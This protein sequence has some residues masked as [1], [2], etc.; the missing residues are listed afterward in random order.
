MLENFEQKC[1]P[2]DA[3]NL[4]MIVLQEFKFE[5]SWKKIQKE[6]EEAQKNFK[7]KIKNN[8]FKRAFGMGLSKAEIAQRESEMQTY[9]EDL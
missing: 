5:D 4:R 6:I 1:N 8:S 2:E 7:K 9:L 3:I